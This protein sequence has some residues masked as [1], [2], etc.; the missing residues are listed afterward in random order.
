MNLEG[1]CT[2]FYD[3]KCTSCERVTL[4]VMEPVK[5]PY[6]SCVCGG[7]TDRVWL[8]GAKTGV[9]ADSIPGGI[10]MKHGICNEDGT[11]K[12]YDSWSE[13]RRAAK[14]KNLVNRVRHIGLPGTDKSPHTTRWV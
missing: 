11:P 12:R 1:S 5:A 10:M 2:P 13:V 3:R 8:P 14:E 7:A 6:V 4:D 9:I